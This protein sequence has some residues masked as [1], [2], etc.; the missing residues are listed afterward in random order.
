MRRD[1]L[2]QYNKR[3]HPHRKVCTFN[4]HSSLRKK[5]TFT[6]PR[7]KEKR[8][9]A[10]GK[11]NFILDEEFSIVLDLVGTGGTLPEKNRKQEKTSCGR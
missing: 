7:T 1:L 2:T 4:Y 10:S 9:R 8:I 3:D 11:G 5:I 6:I